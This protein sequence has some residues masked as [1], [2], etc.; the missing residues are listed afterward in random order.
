MRGAFFADF[1]RCNKNLFRMARRLRFGNC[2][3]RINFSNLMVELETC[4][5]LLEVDFTKGIHENAMGFWPDVRWPGRLAF[6]PSN[7]AYAK[8]K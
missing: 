1:Q 5:V 4:M 2:V 7:V 3:N 8:R 6:V